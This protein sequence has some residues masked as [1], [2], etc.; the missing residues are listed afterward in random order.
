MRDDT[1]ELP[2]TD[3]DTEAD[4]GTGTATTKRRTPKTPPQ[5]PDEEERVRNLL[6]KMP[7]DA[8]IRLKRVN[9]LTKKWEIHGVLTPAETSSEW[10]ARR[11]GGGDYRIEI[12]QRND[13]GT[14]V[15]KNTAQF[16][17]P[18]KY[19]GAQ[20]GL[21][22]IDEPPTATTTT[23]RERSDG[24]RPVA[25]RELID[26]AMA[27]R[28]MDLLSHDNRRDKG[29]DWVGVAAMMTA[30]GAIVTPLLVPVLER[31]L[32]GKPERDPAIEALRDELR[33][34]RAAPGP[35]AGALHDA[36]RGIREVMALMKL[37]TPGGEEKVSTAEKLME[38][39]PA[40]LSAFT[41]RPLPTPVGE[42]PPTG[43]APRAIAEAEHTMGLNADGTANWT[44]IF[45]TYSAQLV[46]MAS[47]GWEPDYSAELVSRSI[48]SSFNGL[49]LEFLQKPEADALE[50]LHTA[51]PELRAYT[52]WT[53]KFLSELRGMMLPE[54]DED[55]DDAPPAKGAKK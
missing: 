5:Y 24:E 17:I 23:T 33:A 49:L 35:T 53:P 16:I 36:T 22:G 8:R 4:E 19:K 45:S 42:G 14:E 27:S 2:F 40:A 48:P 6:D 26:S 47:N 55:E 43:D 21:P 20:N 54:V 34:M 50:L 39:L 11:F 3:S 37:V 38:M 29:T 51:I 7:P 46:G 44:E 9:D 12:M 13:A 25:T 28:V 32:K 30:A 41:G 31:M 52:S 15:V 1:G 10:I 18:G